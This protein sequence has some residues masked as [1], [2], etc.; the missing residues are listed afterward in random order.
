MIRILAMTALLG[1]CVACGAVPPAE[2]SGEA[3]AAARDAGELARPG[4]EP[5]PLSLNPLD[6]GIAE[7]PDARA[8]RY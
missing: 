4:G 3:R 8:G 5:V 6:A 1:L 2:R 7:L